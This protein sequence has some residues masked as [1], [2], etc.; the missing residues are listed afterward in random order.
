MKKPKCPECGEILRRRARKCK[1]C[2]TNV[3]VCAE[4]GSTYKK[5]ETVCNMCGRELKKR[6]MRQWLKRESQGDFTPSD[7]VS[8]INGIKSKSV[9]YKLIRA[10]FWIC[11]VLFC[12]AA[13]FTALI[14][15]MA[16]DLLCDLV[17]LAVGGKG[18][19]ELFAYFINTP[20]RNFDIW[21]ELIGDAT[22]SDTSFGNFLKFSNYLMSALFFPVLLTGIFYIAVYIPI[23]VTE[24]IFL[25]IA[26]IKKGYNTSD[27]LAVFERP[28]L[29]YNSEDSLRKAYT[30]FP[31]AEKTKGRLKSVIVDLLHY[32]AGLVC[33]L[34]GI[35]VFVGQA[36]L[37][38]IIRVTAEYV[39]TPTDAVITL[40]AVVGVFIYI[41]AVLLIWMLKRLF[42]GVI[43]KS[44]L[45][46]W[47]QKKD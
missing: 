7:L 44:Q 5:G 33:C 42:S 38:I 25:G 41:C 30:Y 39:Y 47:A 27:T 9:T 29:V 4:C 23:D 10:I 2:K 19:E 21:I 31:F 37:K 14:G 35:G 3:I 12:I 15:F 20:V 43:Q 32:G 1:R 46:R 26:A 28:T 24:K 36:V 34:A 8:V 45:K 13:I 6:R 22:K 16:G 18:I 11:A 17:V 40:G